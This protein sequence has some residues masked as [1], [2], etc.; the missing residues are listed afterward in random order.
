GIRTDRTSAAHLGSSVAA[1]SRAAQ[2]GG[3]VAAQ[4]GRCLARRT[5]QPKTASHVPTSA[6]GH[7]HDPVVI[8]NALNAMIAEGGIAGH[9]TRRRTER[10]SKR[11]VEARKRL[12]K[13]SNAAS[14]RAVVH[15]PSKPSP[16][17][18]TAKA[19]SVHA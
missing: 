18:S 2:D 8:H 14:P 16:V 7:A 11:N 3:R 13:A 10:T 17:V 9:A 19:S 12:T 4:R 5:N 6:A 15:H 1:R